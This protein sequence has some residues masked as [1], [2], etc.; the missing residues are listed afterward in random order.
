MSF[1]CPNCWAEV[2][3]GAERCPACGRALTGRDEDYVDK[4]IAAL[5]HFEPTRAALAIQILSEMLTEP[6]AIPPLIELL[7]T[8][9][10]AYV[11][12]SAAVALGHLAGV[13]RGALDPAVPALARRLQ[14]LETPLVVRLAAVE[15]LSHIGGDAAWTAIRSGLYDPNAS[16]RERARQALDCIEEI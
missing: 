10:D 12:H 6:R 7:D 15:A 16:M 13:N 11:L 1:Y 3:E 9:R 2:P 8:A 5:R 14:D 4:L